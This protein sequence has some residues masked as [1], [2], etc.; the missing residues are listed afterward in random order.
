MEGRDA[1]YNAGG[2]VLARVIGGATESHVGQEL[3]VQAA[4]P[5]TAHLQLGGG[6]AHIFPGGFL[7]QADTRPVVSTT[8]TSWP[9]GCFSRTNSHRLHGDLSM[10][11]TTTRRTFIQTALK[12]A[13]SAGV[14]LA[15]VPRGWAGAA[16]ASDAPETADIALRHDCADR[17]RADR[18]GAR[19]RLL[20]EVR[21]QLDDLERGVVGGHPRQA[22][23]R[24]ETRRR[25][26]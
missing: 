26:C 10:K 19:A 5:I 7:K 9:P 20:Q 13:T 14:L 16:Y 4:R 12:T 17:L 22:D 24:R 23:A 21:H 6:F 2:A 18:H 8:A 11:K 1:V 15:G 3:D 25:T